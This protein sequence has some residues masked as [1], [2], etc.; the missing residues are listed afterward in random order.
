MA[1]T[2]SKIAIAVATTAS[3]TGC[4]GGGGGPGGAGIKPSV[5]TE[6]SFSTKSVKDIFGWSEIQTVDENEKQDLENL[7]KVF[8]FVQE[9]RYDSLKESGAIIYINNHPRTLEDAWNVL[10]GLTKQ[11]YEGQEEF[12]DK[13]VETGQFNDAD[14]AYNRI[15]AAGNVTSN[16]SDEE[17]F[18]YYLNIG[19]GIVAVAPDPNVSWHN[20]IYTDWTLSNAGVP[21]SDTNDNPACTADV[22]TRDVHWEKVVNGQRTGVRGEHIR[23]ETEERN[24]SCPA[25][26]STQD[27]TSAENSYTEGDVTT[28]TT[29]EDDT[30]TSLDANGSTVTEVWRTVTAVSTI[31]RTTTTVTTVTRVVTY[32]DGTTSSEVIDTETVT[33]TA[34]QVITETSEY[35]LSR[36]VTPNV[37]ET[38]D[39]VST[40]DTV[41][42]GETTVSTTYVDNTTTELDSSGNTVTEVWRTYTDISTTPV[43]TTTVATTTRTTYYTDGSS[44]SEVIDTT[45]TEDTVNNVSTTTREPE[46]I[47]RT[48][49]ANLV[50]SE[51]ISAD[52]TATSTGTTVSETV[53]EDD[54]RTSLDANGSTV[55]EVYRVYTTTNTTPVTTTVTTTQTRVD[56]YTDGTVRETVVD[57]SESSTVTNTVTT[58]TSE[59]LVSR[60]VTPNVANTSDLDVTT[61]ATTVSEPVLAKTIINTDTR[62][63][64][65]WTFY[66]YFWNTTTTVTTTV[67]TTR[68]TN[69]TDGTTTTEVINT[70]ETVNDSVAETIT[71]QI[72]SPEA[73]P[74]APTAP[75]TGS[76]TVIVEQPGAPALDYDPE[77]YNYVSYYGSDHVG[78]PTEVDSH[79]P[80]DFATAEADNGAVLDVNANYA[81]A[82]GW[83]G[84]GSTV[85]IMDTGIDTDHPELAD[86]IKYEW[87]PGYDTGL[88]DTN[89]HGTHV[90]GIV[91]AAK[92]G[93]GTHG[94]AYDAELAIARIGER[95]PS[96]S[97]ARQALNWAKD[98]PDIVAA[99]LS[100]NVVYSTSY[101]DSIT[102]HGDGIFTSNHEIYGDENYYNLE[103][104]QNWADALNGSEIVL[105]V[106]AGNTNLGYVQNPA[107]FA[108]AVDDN[109]NLLLD[110]RMLVVGNW[111]TSANTIEGAKSGHVCKDFT[112]A[113]STCND[114]YLTKDFYILAPGTRINST[115]LDGSY[116]TMSGTSMAAPV[117][118]GA[119][120]I[121][122]QLWPYMEGKNI[123][124]LLLQ[125]ANKN[126]TGYNENTH[127]QG[128]LDLDQATRPVGDLGISLTGRNGATVE[129]SGGISVNGIEAGTLSNVAAVDDYD[130]DFTVDLSSAN[131]ERKISVEYADRQKNNGGWA[132]TMAN[133]SARK[134]D[135]VR[136]AASDNVEE[137]SIGYEHRFFDTN[138]TAGVS[139]TKADTNPWIDMS[140]MWGEVDGSQTTELNLTYDYKDMW[141]QIGAMNTSTRYKTGLVTDVDDIRSVYATVGYD[142][143][144]IAVF[145]GIKPYAVNGSVT[146]R[147]PTSVD[148]DGVMHYDT[149]SSRVRSEL[150]GYVG[151][152]HNYQKKNHSTT[153]VGIVDGGGEG[154]L[155]FNYRY[156]F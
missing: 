98:K 32:S 1:F 142:T 31:P 120:A 151:F 100:A 68:T 69:W 18:D 62:D 77:T 4:G 116:K 133:L 155:N 82:R 126:I 15:I 124:Q 65:V 57:V 111:N 90:A 128:L 52:V 121:V 59:E 89:G 40:I 83:T 17:Q 86:K 72:V 42:Y 67:V 64:G 70:T 76:G 113:T 22:Y 30:R 81:Y 41:T 12:W 7:V 46:R 5:S 36:T 147:L 84:L 55:T 154:H 73:T 34:D 95:V 138:L 99:N 19:S 96:M 141:A 38:G 152:K 29:Y 44:T 11:Y 129:I 115:Y 97:F 94:V 20:G 109:G 51:V 54:T 78:T 61:V 9:H 33:E 150:D 66:Y 105:T 79:D 26:V 125:T 58:A 131:V 112:E 143:D 27:V 47:S 92:D 63:D 101:K 119:V 107:T 71:T 85:M 75:D 146:M 148:A 149:V 16:M 21:T 24:V 106:S 123:A 35:M 102:A 103:N 39:T 80:A 43:T 45:T 8:K 114:P 134:I 74:V 14:D 48:V 93:T 49:T 88:E 118:A 53:S 156:K 91:A 3:L 108:S 137:Y 140:G 135:N 117:V 136:F 60:T 10:K 56:T 132:S 127:G 50:S 6:Y 28:E 104:P 13:V 130:R 122:H 2:K 110:G 144:S 37:T 145:G 87:E 153:F 25:I 139:Y 23:T